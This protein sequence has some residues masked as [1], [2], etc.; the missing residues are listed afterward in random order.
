MEES[1]RCELWWMSEE[2]FDIEM[3]SWCSDEEGE[4]LA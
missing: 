3:L 1:Y 2:E 4:E